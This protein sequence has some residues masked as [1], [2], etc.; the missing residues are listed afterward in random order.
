MTR[1]TYRWFWIACS[2]ICFALP[3]LA[4]TGGGQVCVRAFEDRNANGLQDA[5]EPRIT[6]GIN[7]TLADEQNII[8][9]SGLMEESPTAASGTYC[10]QRLEPGQ[11]RLRVRS[12]DY[13]A[14]T[15]TEFLTALSGT[16]VQ[17]FEYGGQLIPAEEAPVTGTEPDFTLSEAEQRGLLTRLVLSGGG[18][19]LVMA[20]MSVVGAIIYFLFARR[21]PAQVPYSTGTMPQ[22]GVPPSTGAMPPVAG[23]PGY[24]A[25]TPATNRPQ[26]P[27][28]DGTDIPQRPPSGETPPVEDDFD[29]DDPFDSPDDRQG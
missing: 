8:V 11:Y 22:V 10:F 24:G 14:T 23:G 19:L 17:V 7:V 29:F 16:D 5:N 6:R 25:V 1:T 26:M 15:P 12:A 28:D 3:A 4:Q 13:S 27:M 18:A 21:S 20:A 2:L 9:A